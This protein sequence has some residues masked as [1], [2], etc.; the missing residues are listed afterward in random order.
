MYFDKNKIYYVAS[1]LH[2]QGGYYAE[3]I[4]TLEEV[5]RKNPAK[6]VVLIINGDIIDRGPNSIRMLMDV[7][8]RVKDKEG[9][10]EVIMLPGNHEMMMYDALKYVRDN[11][12]KW[13]HSE[14]RT[15]SNIWFDATNHGHET[16]KDFLKLKPNVQEEIYDFL[17]SLPLC[18]T[19]KSRNPNE[20]SYA[21]IHAAPFKDIMTISDEQIPRLSQLVTEKKYEA[22]RVCLT[23]RRGEGGVTSLA[24]P[25]SS[26]ISIVGH[27]PCEWKEGYQIQENGSVIAIDGGCGYIANNVDSKLTGVAT[28]VQL[29]PKGKPTFQV[30]DSQEKRKAGK[31]RR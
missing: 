9:K 29:F 31:V 16:A 26:A 8:K 1:D 28:M 11:N 20:N 6:K 5:Q 13:D 24:V 4:T 14:Q 30:F 23:A 15:H 22:A 2:G 17:G 25:N 27:T 10:I 3:I 18:A 7:M 12:G 19:L 21:I